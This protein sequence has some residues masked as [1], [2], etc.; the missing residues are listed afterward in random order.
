MDW[1][2]ADLSSI[3]QTL[4]LGGVS[5]LAI[6][7]VIKPMVTRAIATL[8]AGNKDD[9]LEQAALAARLTDQSTPEAIKL[10]DDEDVEDMINIDRIQGKVKSSNYNKINN[11]VDKH[12]EETAQILR[13]W[14][15][16]NPSG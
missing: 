11:L 1:L 16:A 3:I 12:A 6:L 9:E 8:E 13:Q 2:K 14:L 7:L 4:V 15:A 10:D 5:I